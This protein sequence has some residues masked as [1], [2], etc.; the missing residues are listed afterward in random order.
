M[1]DKLMTE[2]NP[3]APWAQHPSY[4]QPLGDPGAPIYPQ[5]PQPKKRWKPS[6]TQAIAA[7]AAV[8]ALAVGIAIGQG[9][10]STPD[11]CA[12]ALDYAEQALDHSGEAM[13]VVSDA[14]GG[15]YIALSRVP[16][17]LDPITADLERITPLYQDAR[18]ECLK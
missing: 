2:Q 3:Q 1:K 14:L 18:A 15:S 10:A 7:A 4:Q 5:A 16:D 13:G 8:I 11:E 17:R 12:V 6:P 9:T